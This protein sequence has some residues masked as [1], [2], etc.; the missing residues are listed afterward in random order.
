MDWIKRL[1]VWGVVVGILGILVAA[2]TYFATE[3]VG[4]ISYSFDTQK[5]FDPAIL[6]GFILV[7][8]NGDPIKQAV[9]ATDLVI[10]NS[11]DISLS[12]NS[13][14]MRE[15]IKVAVDGTIHYFILNK[16]NVVSAENY[17][18]V[19]AKDNKSLSIGWRYFDP[20]Q[21]IR[22]TLIHSEAEKSK[23][24]ISGRFFETSLVEQ[25]TTPPSQTG[26]NKIFAII[27]LTVFSLLVVF[28]FVLIGWRWWRLRSRFGRTLELSDYS[29]AAVSIFM[30]ISQIVIFSG[31]FAHNP[32]V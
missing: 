29:L 14:R 25:T 21:G 17:N 3:K 4:Q 18:L 22:L 11:G 10:W 8:A 32:P 16:F 24:T 20:P 6:S 31:Y 19:V 9:Y 15:P 7:G 1:D 30:L 5:V 12:E 28:I 27:T 23:V 13:D 2:Y 26:T